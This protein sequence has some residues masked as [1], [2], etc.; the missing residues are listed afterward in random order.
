MQ[1]HYQD[2]MAMARFFKNIDLLITMTT[3]PD[4]IEIQ[5]EL[6]PGQSSYDQPDLVA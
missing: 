3:N 2:A 6:L 4:W 5:Q 1:Q